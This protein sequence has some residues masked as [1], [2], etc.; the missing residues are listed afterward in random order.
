M[1]GLAGTETSLVNPSIYLD[2]NSLPTAGQIAYYNF[3]F[4]MNVSVP[5]AVSVWLLIP[6]E[7][8]APAQPSCSTFGINQQSNNSVLDCYSL[9]AY[10]AIIVEQYS[11]Q[12]LNTGTR[13]AIKVSLLNP[14]R[15]GTTGNFSILVYKSDTSYVVSSY[16]NIA[17]VVIQQGNIYSATFVPYNPYAI[18]SINKVMDYQLSFTPTN[19]LSNNNSIVV[20]LPTGFTVLSGSGYDYI[21]VTEGASGGT[22]SWTSN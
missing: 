8:V 3:I 15:T 1:V 13:L 17:G 7:F 5:Y 21:R 20:D 10:N 9:S 18:Q 11:S 2:S 4:T 16:Y 22:L 6:S 14:N 12:S 19:P